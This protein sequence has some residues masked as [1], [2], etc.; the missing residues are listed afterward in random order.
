MNIRFRA[1]KIF[2]SQID[3]FWLFSNLMY[4]LSNGVVR[5]FGLY[6]AVAGSNLFQLTIVGPQASPLS[7]APWY[8]K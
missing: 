3:C 4:V 2:I 1:L 7:L 5:A 6:W 8:G